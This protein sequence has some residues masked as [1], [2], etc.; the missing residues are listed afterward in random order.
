MEPGMLDGFTLAAVL[1]QARTFFGEISTPVFW[2]AGIGIAIG[3]AN[4]A[5]AKARQAR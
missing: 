2:I 4:W 5:I 1:A 3:L